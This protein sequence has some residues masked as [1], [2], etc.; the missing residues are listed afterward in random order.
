MVQLF[1]SDLEAAM[2]ISAL[3]RE[4]CIKS[5]SFGTTTTI[6]FGKGESPDLSC[7]NA[8]NAHIQA[9][10]RNAQEIVNMFR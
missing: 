5:V 3:P 8:R 9:L 10:M 2:P 6:A 1:Y 4:R 7:P